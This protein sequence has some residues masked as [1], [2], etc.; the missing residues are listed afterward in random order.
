MW[1]GHHVEKAISTDY[2]MRLL[3]RVR[4][5]ASGTL[6]W[7]RVVT[8]FVVAVLFN[9]PWE[10]AQSGLY[11]GKDGMNIPWWHCVPMSLGDGLLVL[12][13]FFIGWTILGR[14]EWFECP[15][16]RGYAVILVS[17]LAISISIEWLMVHIY[18]RWTYTP[19]MP[20]VPGLRV[21]V[22]PVAQMVVLPLL[23]FRA[24]TMVRGRKALRLDI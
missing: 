9:L 5:T 1:L 21:G 4:R 22:T 18:V 8:I 15:G 12:L 13:I 16:L 3:N 20:L 6:R 7:W 11:R 17:G 2:W 19:Q 14:P 24:V 23:V 10:L